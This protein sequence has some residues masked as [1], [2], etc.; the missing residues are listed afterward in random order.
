MFK[1]GLCSVTFRNHSVDQVIDLAKKASLQGIEW[2]ADI[3]VPPGSLQHAKEVKNKTTNA[4]LEVVSYG[5]YYRVGD[6]NEYSFKEIL[7]TA[8]ELSAPAI[9]VWAGTLGSQ[10]ATNVYR[11]KVVEDAKR[12]GNLADKQGVTV[13]FE[14]HGN[15]LTDTMESAKQLMEEVNHSNIYLYWQPAVGRTIDDRLASIQTIETWLS[16]VHVFHWTPT[17]R[18]SLHE[19]KEEWNKYLNEIK[20]YDKDNYLFM[21]F[22]KNDSE[23]QFLKDATTLHE[24]VSK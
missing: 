7:E 19:G 10:E 4:K 9:R 22:V 20:K 17:D 2:G 14:Y 11:E 21:E 15:T 24:L 6:E 5:S 16:H 8:L 13:H 1:L 12:I 23:D 18:L 3:H